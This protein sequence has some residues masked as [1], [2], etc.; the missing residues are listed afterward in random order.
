[1]ALVVGTNSYISVAD[2]DT[3]F[4]DRLNADEWTGTD[5]DKALIQAT[6]MIDFRHYL[7]Y[8]TDETQ[9]L[10]FPRIGLIDDYVDLDE[11]EVPQ[12]VK[13]AT[14][15]LALYLLQDDYSAPDDLSEFN[16]VV[17]GP[18]QIETRVGAKTSAGGKVIPPFVIELL[19]FAMAPS[20]RLIRG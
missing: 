10:K 7:G 15:E 6:K 12:K 5:K 14:C 4:S 1:M 19:R 18:I 8:K 11:N 3:Y 2:A 16:N 9:A 20:G 17:V 13:D